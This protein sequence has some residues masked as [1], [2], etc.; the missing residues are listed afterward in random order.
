MLQVLTFTFL[1]VTCPTMLTISHDDDHFARSLCVQVMLQVLTFAFLVVI[2][3]TVLMVPVML[4]VF[5]LD[6]LGWRWQHAA[7]FS[8]M[9]A[10]TDA[11]TVSA[12]LHSGER[13]I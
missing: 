3:S 1:V 9:V 6:E 12:I 5:R 8:S 13:N 11:V 10:S 4:Y 7:L 2:C